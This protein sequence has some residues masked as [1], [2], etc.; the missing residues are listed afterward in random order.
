MNDC[1]AFLH[2]TFFFV[3][4]VAFGPSFVFAEKPAST[5]DLR[6]NQ[7]QVVGTHNSYHLRPKASM[8]KL[9][10]SFNRGAEGWD[11]EHAP[12]DVQLDRGVRSFELDLHYKRGDFEVFH[13]PIL[14]DQTSCRDFA[15]CLRLV[16]TWSDRHPRHVPI[17]FLLEIKDEVVGLDPEIKPVDKQGLDLIDKK[18][19]D[20]FPDDRIITP[21]QVRGNFAT[22]EEAVLAGAWP[23]LEESRGKVLFIL[24]EGGNN[25]EMYVE[26]HPSLAGRAMFVRSEPGRPDAATLVR[27]NPRD[28]EIPKLVKTG[29][30]VRTTADGDVTRNPAA[31]LDRR[32]RAWE[33][34]AQ[35]VSTDYPPGE[36]H[37]ATGYTVTIE[38]GAPA[39]PNPINTPRELQNAEIVEPKN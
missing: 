33:S 39:I 4:Q 28:E 21:D 23:L 5:K 26:G 35:I 38:S 3:G 31:A 37:A 15:D 19:R 32:K 24:H 13:V 25:R 9:A 8:F 1:A 12:L 14:D 30:F 16:K 10:T 7:L 2:I 29:Y 27:D 36:T 20:V 34:G 11:Y 6:I 17:S 22:L 18:I